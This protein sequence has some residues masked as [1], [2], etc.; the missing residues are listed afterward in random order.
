M[1]VIVGLGNP[2]RE[3]AKTRHNVGFMTIDK[4][5][6]RLNI[7]VNKKG[8]RSV[9]GEGRL[10]GTRVVLA[11]PETFM[12]NSGWAVGDLLKWYK[13]QHDELIV[14]YDDIDLPCGALR[15]RMND[16]FAGHFAD[17]FDRHRGDYLSVAL[18]AECAAE[19]EIGIRETE[20]ER[21]AN[22]FSGAGNRLEIA[23]AN[24]Y[25]IEIIEMLEACQKLPRILI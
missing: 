12:N 14:I 4:I 7:S 16:L 15:I 8:F 25:I 19:L 18:A 24:I 22:F 13:P 5:A 1:F 23:V 9:Y 21:I 2:G 6:E 20:A 10:G 11:K 17:V 3:Y